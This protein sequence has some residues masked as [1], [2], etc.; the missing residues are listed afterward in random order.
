[1]E[2]DD[3]LTEATSVPT[4]GW[5]FSWLGSRLQSG[6]LPWDYDAL[7]CAHAE[8]SA[9]LLDLG[10]GG[11]E[12]LAAL[13]CRPSRVVATEGYAPNFSIAAA[14]LRP[15]GIDVFPADAPD[16]VAQEPRA[17]EPRLPF[18]DASFSLVVA[19]HESYLPAEIARV[20]RPRGVF[21]TQQVGER[22][23]DDVHVLLGR[24]P[25]RPSGWN[26]AFARRQLES[27]DL[28]VTRTEEA[29]ITTTFAD[30][31]ALVWW[32]RM[33]AFSVP[34]SLERDR[35]RLIELHEAE[36]PLVLRERRFLLEAR[37][38]SY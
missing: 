24:R 29:E 15:L 36:T 30:I 26:A 22:N 21:L 20:L 10:T 33:I 12:W 18:S 32:L 6:P 8:R 13:P 19:R 27:A 37:K 9:D 38:A 16:N 34:F 17:T 7:V 35:D 25:P 14:R 5:D 1:M 23:E 4:G 31:G 2:I 11:G 3:L 28:E